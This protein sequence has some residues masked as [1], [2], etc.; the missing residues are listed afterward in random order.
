M[1]YSLLEQSLWTPGPPAAVTGKAPTALHPACVCHMSDFPRKEMLRQSLV[2]EAVIRNCSG[3]ISVKGGMKNQNQTKREAEHQ[4]NLSG[5]LT[6]SLGS[7]KG[8][9]ILQSWPESRREGQHFF[10]SHVD[11]SLLE[12]DLG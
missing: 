4:C 12:C 3:S 6:N 9:M 2:C 1:N 8:G 5:G 10:I 7:C 11:Q